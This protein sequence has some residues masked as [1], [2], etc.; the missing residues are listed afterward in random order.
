MVLKALNGVLLLL[1][2]LV[3]LAPTSTMQGPT[4]LSAVDVTSGSQFFRLGDLSTSAIRIYIVG[5]NTTLT[6]TASVTV[7][8]V[9]V[10]NVVSVT[11]LSALPT[12]ATLSA[13]SLTV[14]QDVGSFP[15]VV[16]WSGTHNVLAYPTGVYA[17]TALTPLN[18]TASV[19]VDSV[20]V[21]NVVSTSHVGLQAVIF[22]G[23]QNVLAYPTGV[24]STSHVGP[25][26]TVI[27]GTANVLAYPTGIYTVTTSGTTNI[28]TLAS[29]IDTV[30]TVPSG[31]QNI[32]TLSHAIDAVMVGD[33]T[34]IQAIDPCQQNGAA[35]TSTA[36]NISGINNWRIVTAAAAKYTYICSIYLFAAGTV[37]VGIVEGTGN[38]CATNTT[39]LVGGTTAATGPNLIAQTGFTLGNGAAFVIAAAHTNYD[40]CLITSATQ[41]LSGVLTWVQK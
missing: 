10:V 12:T 41:Q 38:Q 35:K 36:V 1:T 19:T 17:I 11:A 8:A 9:T 31:T 16:S 26:L 32:R 4:P 22:S 5:S 3:W 40:F 24:Q 29:G 30:T 34:S 14:R 23:T 20:T 33:G 6:T 15:W 2:L 21:V 18:T 25:A 28:R 39:G 37:N 13:S 27:S 7:D